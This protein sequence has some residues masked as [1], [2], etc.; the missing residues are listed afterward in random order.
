MDREKADAVINGF[1]SQNPELFD[2]TTVA[3]SYRRGKKSGLHDVDFLIV[4]EGMH[5]RR[6]RQEIEGEPV[7]LVYTSK[8]SFGP[9]LLY[10][11]GSKFFNIRTRVQ[12]NNLG[13]KLNQYG[14]FEKEDARMDDNTEEGI[15]ELLKMWREPEDRT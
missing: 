11:T 10:L 1:F 8:S 12:A 15:L 13:C 5:G 6:I 14:L 2:V 4:D 7:D 9:A 3:G